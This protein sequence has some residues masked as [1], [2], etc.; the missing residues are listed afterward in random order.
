MIFNP[1]DNHI[2][3][4]EALSRNSMRAKAQ[5]NLVE[6][7]SPSLFWDTNRAKVDSVKHRRWIVQRVLERGSWTDW[8]TIRDAFTVP[9]IVSEAQ[10]L[11]SLDPKALSFIS[12]VGGVAPEAF[13]CSEPDPLKRLYWNETHTSH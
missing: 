13:R 8:T 6:R 5:Q 3:P 9:V 4:A 10:R 12:C 11:R 7:L 2:S 1:E